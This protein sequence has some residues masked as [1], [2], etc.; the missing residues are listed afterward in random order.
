MFIAHRGVVNKIQKENTIPAFL[1]A[2]NNNKYC[3]FEL[4]VY[5]TKDKEFIVH[6]NPVINGKFIWKYNYKELKEKG[7]VKL[8]EVLKLKKDINID[9]I[10]FSKLLNKYKDKKIYVMSFFNSVIAKFSNIKF[11]V[12]VL[13]YILNS[14]NDYK[15]DFIGLLYDVT[16]PLMIS[17]FQDKKIE[18]F[19]Y[20]LNK[21]DKFIYS[22]VYYIVDDKLIS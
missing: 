20:A 18:I 15:Y 9:V 6:H 1:N 2:I 22:D 3:G 14:T 11:K 16:T 19:L 12:G 17:Y 13:N 21:K 4:D 5:T 8:E 10:K 7:L